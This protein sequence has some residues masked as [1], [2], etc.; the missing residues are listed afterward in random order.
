LFFAR[1]SGPAVELAGRLAQT[2][3]LTPEE[4]RFYVLWAMKH[5]LLERV[6]E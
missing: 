2:E 4:A 3:A 1:K 6:D 5:D